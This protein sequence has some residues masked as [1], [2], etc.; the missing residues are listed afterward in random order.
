[1]KKLQ[2]GAGLIA[3]PGWLGTDLR[4]TSEHV[5]FLDAT[6]PFPFDDNTFDYIHSEHMIEHIPWQEGCFMLHEC[7]RVIKPGGKIRIATPNLKVFIDIYNNEGKIAK[8]YIEW[9]T[10][11]YLQGINVYRAAFII[12]S[13][14][15]RWNHKFVYDGELLEMAMR[16]AGFVNI[17]LHKVGESDDENF[18]GVEMHGRIGNYD[19]ELNAFE[20]M[21]YE[22]VKQIN[23]SA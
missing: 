21:V 23:V 22:G 19:E 4:P 18:R 1:M 11:H 16:D 9:T 13:L 17:K 14:F 2:I 10:D 3:L 12:N 5:A 15:Y 6:K 20:T 8:R 7:Y